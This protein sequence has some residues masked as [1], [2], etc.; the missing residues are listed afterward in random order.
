MS[1]EFKSIPEKQKPESIQ[2]EYS[3]FFFYIQ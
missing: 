3:G 1:I 2:Q